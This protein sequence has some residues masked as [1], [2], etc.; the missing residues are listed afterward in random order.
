MLSSSMIKFS[1][2]Q[3]LHTAKSVSK[4]ALDMLPS[5]IDLATLQK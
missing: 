3:Q 4:D 1:N 2:A 5:N